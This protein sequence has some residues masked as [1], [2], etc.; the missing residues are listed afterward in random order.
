MRSRFRTGVVTYVCPMLDTTFDNRYRL[1]VV[2][3]SPAGSEVMQTDLG[4]DR[5]A[6]PLEYVRSGIETSV[7]SP[8]ASFGGLV[9]PSTVT[10]R[11]WILP[12]VVV[13]FA[14]AMWIV[15]ATAPSRQPPISTDDSRMSQPDGVA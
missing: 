12:S 9:H 10:R 5:S 2:E 7:A 6:E 3:A 8:L 13:A 15:S 1:V 14:A 4:D 11:W